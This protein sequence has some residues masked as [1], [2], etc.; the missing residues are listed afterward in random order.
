MAN[1]ELHGLHPSRGRT[2]VYFFIVLAFFLLVKI[3]K[4]LFFDIG[5][6]I[7]LL[8]NPLLISFVAIKKD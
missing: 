4:K 2:L 8:E 1:L 3:L 6:L 5:P 7:S